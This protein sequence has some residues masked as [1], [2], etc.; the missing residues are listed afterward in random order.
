MS[1]DSAKKK[2]QIVGTRPVKTEHRFS[3]L[4]NS[5][6]ARHEVKVIFFF[7]NLFILL[8]PIKCVVTCS[9][10]ENVYFMIFI[11]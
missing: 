10:N 8:A 9:D 6:A 11:K 3:L 4:E 2:C 7:T 5:K 1:Y